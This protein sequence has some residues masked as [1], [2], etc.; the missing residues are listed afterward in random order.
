VSKHIAGPVCASCEE[1]LKLAKTELVEWFHDLKIR[2][3]SCH[4]SWSYRDQASQEDAFATG[5]TRL[6][7]PQSAHNKMPSEALDIFQ[8]ND[9][10]QAIF[11]PIFCAKVAQEIRDAKLPII[12]GG[13]FK[14]L[15][16][17]DHF[18]YH[19]DT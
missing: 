5:H 4:V 10:G 19:T 15:G 17:N 11:D 1:K 2:N 14:S 12:W 16:D 3:P 6:H 7:F 9:Q 13:T 18:Q 8:I